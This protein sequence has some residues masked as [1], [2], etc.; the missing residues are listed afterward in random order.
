[1][2]ACCRGSVASRAL[3]CGVMV[4]LLL[5]AGGLDRQAGAAETP[6][7]EFFGTYEGRTLFPMGEAVNRELRV[8]IGPFDLFGF[9]VSWETT[10]FKG[11]KGASRKAQAMT[12]KP[13]LRAG[14]YAM[15]LAEDSPPDPISGDPYAWATLF[16]KTLTVNVF[17]ITENGDYVVQSYQR[18][19]TE[20]GLAL[21]FTRVRNGRP[22]KQIKGTLERVEEKL[23][24][25]DDSGQ[26]PAPS[27]NLQPTDKKAPN[28]D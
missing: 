6:L 9:T 26:P 12:F 23:P 27:E 1:M 3:R 5:A 2:T 7:Q 22:E 18:T 21:V 28:S 20:K 24:P 17:T 11:K 4:L 16:G 14:V 15:V 25:P 13:T 10:I 19:L 8:A